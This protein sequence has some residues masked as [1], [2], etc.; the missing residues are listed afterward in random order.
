MVTADL[1]SKFSVAEALK[2]AHS[3]FLV[4]NYWETA[5][6]G[7]ERS[8]GTTVADA[9]KVTCIS[10]LIYSSLLNASKA[11]NGRLKE[12]KHFDEKADIEEHIRAS[13]VPC[14]FFL[15][16]YFMANY[17]FMIHKEGDG[18]YVLAS[19]FSLIDAAQD[20]GKWVKAIIK[21]REKL[22]EKR[23]LTTSDFYTSEQIVTESV[24]VLRAYQ[25]SYRH[26]SRSL[27]GKKRRLDIKSFSTLK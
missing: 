19:S 8:Q 11:T 12:V 22:L 18:S 9:A 25:W 2:G 7:V 21:N 20:T 14:S 3:D 26:V 6:P 23:I 15:P 17:T 24:F 1:N 10:H 4:T 13:R 5:T 27:S 16:G